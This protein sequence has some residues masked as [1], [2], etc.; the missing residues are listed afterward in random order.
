MKYKRA[1][2][3][4][5][6]PYSL[7]FVPP[8]VDN[9]AGILGISHGHILCSILV[10]SCQNPGLNCIGVLKAW[11]FTY[12]VSLYPSKWHLMMGVVFIY[13]LFY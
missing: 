12:P 1:T 3:E 5:I 7:T 6:N 13:P 8:L 9:I 4:K 11:Y 2:S 10:V